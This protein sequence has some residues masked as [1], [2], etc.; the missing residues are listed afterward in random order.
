[1]KRAG[2]AIFT[3]PS[4]LLR[5]PLPTLRPTLSPPSGVSTTHLQ[6]SAASSSDFLHQSPAPA[7]APS[8]APAPASA[9]VGE[10]GQILQ[11][12]TELQVLATQG[13][14]SVRVCSHVRVCVCVLDW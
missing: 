9:P 5:T 6:N 14:L 11:K 3:G 7:L 13:T 12:V 1:M 8:P 4:S 10:I 2:S